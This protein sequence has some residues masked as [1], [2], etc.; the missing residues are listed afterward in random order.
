M[1]LSVQVIQELMKLMEEHKIDKLKLD[2]LELIKTRHE[3]GKT[4][5]SSNKLTSNIVDDEELLFWSTSTPAL[6]PEQ[7]EALSANPPPPPK[8]K[9]KKTNKDK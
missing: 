1:E 5:N 6:T 8:T 7:I 3:P 9:T 4:D 2:S